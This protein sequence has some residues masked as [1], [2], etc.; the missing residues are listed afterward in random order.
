MSGPKFGNEKLFSDK[1]CVLI[2]DK[3]INKKHMEILSKF[4]VKLDAI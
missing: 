3:N 2:K 4:W 1:W